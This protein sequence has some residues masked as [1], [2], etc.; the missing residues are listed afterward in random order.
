M[1]VGNLLSDML[2]GVG[3]KALRAS[4]A[5]ENLPQ[6]KLKKPSRKHAKKRQRAAKKPQEPETKKPEVKLVDLNDP[7][8]IEAAYGEGATVHVD[9]NGEIVISRRLIVKYDAE[10]QRYHYGDEVY[11]DGDIIWNDL[12]QAAAF[13]ANIFP[14]VTPEITP[15]SIRYLDPSN[16]RLPLDLDY[17]RA[18]REAAKR[19]VPTYA[20]VCRH[21][22][23]NVFVS[24]FYDSHNAP[25]YLV[26]V[27]NIMPCEAESPRLFTSVVAE[28]NDGGIDSV[29]VRYCS[30]YSIDWDKEVADYYKA[31]QDTHEH[32]MEMYKLGVGPNPDA[33]MYDITEGPLKLPP[34][35]EQKLSEP[36]TTPDTPEHLEPGS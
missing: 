31:L 32:G 22:H 20:I 24:D 14:D 2:L 16:P 26:K 10:T 9:E 3:I 18:H 17:A 29:F 7:E 27:H 1:L 30:G 23:F 21:G 36:P 19:K 15:I 33:S 5:V 34:E 6:L 12:L 28:M 8:S 35:L 4:K 25:Y 13:C 11:Q